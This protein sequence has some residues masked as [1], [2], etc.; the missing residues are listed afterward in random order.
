MSDLRPGGI[1]RIDGE[2]I[3]VVSR[4]DYISAGEPIE[5]IS[6]EGYRRVV[7]RLEAREGDVTRLSS[8]R[9]S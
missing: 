4:G 8:E 6:D 1:A 9:G 2:R 3:D 5:V 7:R